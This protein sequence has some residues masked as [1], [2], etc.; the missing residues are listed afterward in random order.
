MKDA[1]DII[2][3]I[4]ATEKSAGLGEKQRKYFF[5][6]APDANKIEIKRAVE[7]LFKVSVAEVNTMNYFGKKKRVRGP[8]YG[9]KPDWKRAVVTLKE[10]GKIDLTA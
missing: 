2:R 7:E 1:G 5:R 3:D 9:R 4:Q 6:V 8:K 10:G